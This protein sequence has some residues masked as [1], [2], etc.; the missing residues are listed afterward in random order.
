MSGSLQETGMADIEQDIRGALGQVILEELGRSLLDAGALRDLRVL[1]DR[2]MLE[3]VLG[4]PVEDIRDLLTEQIREALVPV[5]GARQLALRLSWEVVP[6]RPQSGMKAL[7]RASNIIAVASG[8]GGVGKSTTAVNLALALKA[9]GAKVGI[10]DADVFGPSQPIMLGLPKDTRPRIKDEQ[11]FLP[12]QAHGIEVMSMGFLVDERSPVVWRGPKASGALQQLVNQ[13]L[14]GNLDYLIVDLPPGT[15]D[16]Q[17]TL[18]QRVPVAGSVI[19][20]TP[21]DIALLDARKG[22]EMFRKVGVGVLGVVE[23]MAMHVCSSCGHAEHIFGSGGGERIAADY[24]TVLLGSL[25]LTLAIREQ[26]DGGNPT[27]V[28]APESTEAVIYR[29]TAR[30]MAARLSLLP[31]AERE[32][33]RVVTEG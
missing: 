19:V 22:I 26:A 28:A 20:T 3:V 33:P 23:N 5:I 12:V 2:V 24:D 7:D 29:D 11:F 15:G 4:Y 6:H 16:I 1:D 18:A 14:W 10:L 8:K 31:P 32:F 9:Q 17:L 25:P 13:T 21:Q 27:V 30:R